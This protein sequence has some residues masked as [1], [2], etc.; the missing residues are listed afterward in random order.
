MAQITSVLKNPNLTTMAPS[1]PHRYQTH[2]FCS[3]CGAPFAQA[4]RTATKPIY[5]ANSDDAEGEAEERDEDEEENY[6]TDISHEFN[7]S[8]SENAVIP[9]EV[10]LKDMNEGAKRERAAKARRE[11]IL[12]E[13]DRRLREKRGLPPKEHTSEHRT[14]RTAYDGRLISIKDMEWSKDLRAIINQHAQHHPEDHQ[15]NPEYNFSSTYLTGRGLIRQYDNEA[16]AYAAIDFE[17]YEDT[18]RP[19]SRYPQFDPF[20]N[21]KFHL[22]QEPNLRPQHIVCSFPFHDECYSLL[23]SA[24]EAIAE[25]LGWE[26]TIYWDQDDPDNEDFNSDQ[27]FYWLREFLG[28]V[29]D[30]KKGSFGPQHL[31]EGDS[32]KEV[33]TRLAEINYRE[34]QGCS[35][36]Y[37]WRHEDGLHVSLRSESESKLLTNLVATC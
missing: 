17:E 26:G 21:H 19:P 15:L 11:M 35:E 30:V 3:L 4:Y 14:V 23:D 24:L 25:D 9:P 16:D 1:R 20:R 27:K 31:V 18:S 36:G 37:Q 5:A 10:W 29:P 34:A 6:N 33:S 28:G 12:D 8:E 22:Y 7:I 13:K 2:F 32:R